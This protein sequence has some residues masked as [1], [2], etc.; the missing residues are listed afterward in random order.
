VNARPLQVRRFSLG[1]QQRFGALSG[2]VNPLHVDVVAARRMIFGEVVVHGLHI[3]LWALESYLSSAG[4]PLPEI[5]G[6]RA[7]F[8]KPIAL[9]EEVAVSC[10]AQDAER[11]RLEVNGGSTTF[12]TLEITLGARPT[13]VDEP[14]PPTLAPQSA[15]AGRP[16]DRSFAELAGL[17]GEVPLSLDAAMAAR[18][19]PRAVAALGPTSFAAFLALTRLVGM[20]CPGAQSLFSS[21]DLHREGRAAVA[22]FALAYCVER[23]DVAAAPVRIAV[24][25]PGWVGGVRAFYRPAPA[26][27]PALATVAVRIGGD[28]LA[29]QRALVVGGSRGLGETTAKLVACGG[30]HP[31]ITYLAGEEDAQR[32]ADEIR[33]NGRS[34]DVLRLDVRDPD[35]ALADLR[36]RAAAITHLY[37]FATPRITLVRRALYEPERLH[38]FIAY[39]V[40]GFYR[41]CREL[42]ATWPGLKVFLPSTVFVE[43]GSRDNPEYVIAKA[44]AEALC[45]YLGTTD[46]SFSVLSRRLPRVATDQ[47]T[48]L[49]KVPVDDTLSVMLPIV[50][51]LAG[52]KTTDSEGS[53]S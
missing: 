38:E 8:L 49:I 5:V 37:F 27:Q 51:A 2:D 7:S 17:L 50:R 44:A 47:T 12:V 18:E 45:H 6:V 14:L 52:R 4:K 16:R 48:T 3:A 26:V 20:E 22:P 41:L 42:G 31:I 10:V 36:R 29:G 39:Y 15:P 33:R 1:D 9:D 30:G 13:A 40:D 21:F 32:V 43:Q 35:A 19:F 11:V 53:P 25:A 46:A 28:E 23:A 24:V 34:C